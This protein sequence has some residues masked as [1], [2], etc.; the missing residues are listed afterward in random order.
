[1]ARIGGLHP[2]YLSRFGTIGLRSPRSLTSPGATVTSRKTSPRYMPPSTA[3]SA[4]LEAGDEALDAEP[5]V[6][7]DPDAAAELPSGRMPCSAGRCGEGHL[8]AD[9]LEPAARPAIV[10]DDPAGDG[11]VRLE[12]ERQR[13][14][15][16][17]LEVDRADELPA[18]VGDDHAPG[19]RRVE[20]RTSTVVD[21]WRVFGRG[22]QVADARRHRP[23]D[24][25]AFGVDRIHH[26]RAAG[27]NLDVQ[28]R[29]LGPGVEVDLG[30]DVVIADVA[31]DPARPEARSLGSYPLIASAPTYPR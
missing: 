17:P 13:P 28:R 20:P 2:P 12:P 6:A 31:V 16:V 26:E 8:R 19:P 22:E 21:G 27:V 10:V 7:A 9:E 1:M 25:L 24:R 5:A 14:G 11:A 18:G 23:G 29:R 15:L 3:L 30:H 4:I